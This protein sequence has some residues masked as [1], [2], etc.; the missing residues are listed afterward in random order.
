MVQWLFEQNSNN[1][2]AHLM[3]E[4]QA[5]LLNFKHVMNKEVQ[6]EFLSCMGLYVPISAFSTKRVIP[7]SADERTVLES[8]D[9]YRESP[10]AGEDCTTLFAGFPTFDCDGDN[11]HQLLAQPG[12]WCSSVTRTPSI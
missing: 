1:V 4:V 6:I 7:Q 3:P 10:E 2:D 12:V 11:A 9:T 8:I 5:L